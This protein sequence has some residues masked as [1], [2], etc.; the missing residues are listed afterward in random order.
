MYLSYFGIKKW[1]RECYYVTSE[2][3]M[4]SIAMDIVWVYTSG[5]RKSDLTIFYAV[6]ISSIGDPPKYGC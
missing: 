1:T 5:E 3:Y 2:A 6:D 4:L